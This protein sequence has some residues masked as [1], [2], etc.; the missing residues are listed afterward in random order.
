M[1]TSIQELEHSAS[2]VMVSVRMFLF[3]PFKINERREPVSRVSFVGAAIFGDA[4]TA[5]SRRTS[6]PE[7]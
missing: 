6:V 5:P 1:M 3:K 7:F 4:R 2:V